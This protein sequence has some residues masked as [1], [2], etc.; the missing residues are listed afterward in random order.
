M[1]RVDCFAGRCVAVSFAGFS[2]V[3]LPQ[4]SLFVPIMASFRPEN[5]AFLR[6]SRPLTAC[7]RVQP[8]ARGHLRRVRRA[9]VRAIFRLILRNPAV[10]VSFTLEQPHEPSV[11]LSG[12][13]FLPPF[14][15][16]QTVENQSERQTQN[17]LR[18]SSNLV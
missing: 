9:F 5:T 7:R 16:S 18:L 11:R 13:A 10:K 15:F 2:G 17:L 6:P 14:P 1:Y 12:A 8:A 4:I 3:L